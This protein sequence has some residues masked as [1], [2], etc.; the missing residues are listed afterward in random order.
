MP[1]GKYTRFHPG[2]R[3]RVLE[4]AGLDTGKVGVIVPRNQVSTRGDGVPNI[5]GHYKPM[6]TD[7]YPIR[8]ENTGELFT[9]FR[10]WLGVAK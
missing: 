5:P 4:G 9:M 8:D 6:S 10:Y 1:R 3:V 7:E 2:M